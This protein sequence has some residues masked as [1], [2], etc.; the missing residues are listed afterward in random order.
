[1]TERIL[2]SAVTP[3]IERE[4]YAA[5]TRPLWEAL[6]SVTKR[7]T[8][9]HPGLSLEIGEPPYDLVK[10][11]KSQVLRELQRLSPDLDGKGPEDDGLVFVI[12]SFDAAMDPVFDAVSCAAASVGLRAERVKDYQ[13][14]YRITD[15]ILTLIR[16]ARLIVADLSYERPNVY[17]ELGYARGLGKTVI[18]M[19]R[20]GTIPH[21]DVRDWTYL[22]YIDSRPLECLLRERFRFEI[23]SGVPV[24]DRDPGTAVVAT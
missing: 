3:M 22:E 18:T 8:R 5:I 20:T 15:K 4:P 17:F 6:T 16:S 12:C 19:V 11:V 1:M 9:R 13:G 21:F 23:K 10:E 24:A 14:D 7:R 2:P